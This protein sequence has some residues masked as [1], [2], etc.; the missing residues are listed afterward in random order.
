MPPSKEKKPIEIKEKKLILAEGKDAFLFCIWAYQGFGATGIQ[1]LNFG[2]VTELSSFLEL[3]RGVPNYEAL[4]TIVIV[5]DAERDAI[6]AVSSIKTSLKKAKLP[7]P[8]KSYEFAGSCP[9][10]AYIIFPGFIEGTKESKSL[11]NGTLEDLCLELVKE[12]EIFECVN[13]Y[14]QCLKSKRQ[15]VRRLH[16][17]KL[18]TYLAGKNDFV[19]LKIGEAARVGAWDWNHAKLEPFKQVILG[20]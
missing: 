19:G 11:S 18:H 8:S 16:K 5:R 3:I 1:V 14:I 12:D 13:Q 17:A 2:G 15:D 6:A 4:E 7:V 20:M 9:K 10:V